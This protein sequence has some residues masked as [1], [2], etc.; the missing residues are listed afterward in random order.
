VPPEPGFSV[1]SQT[2]MYGGQASRAVL[3]GRQTF[4]LTAFALYEFLGASYTF[5]QLVLGGR[6][7]I[8]AAVPV[9]S[10]ATT[11]V[12]LQTRLFGT[13]SGGASDFNVGA[14]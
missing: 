14:P 6:L 5:E 10:Y 3:N 7:Q 8:G 12:S 11:T 9:I 4:G 13:F 2:L 1:A